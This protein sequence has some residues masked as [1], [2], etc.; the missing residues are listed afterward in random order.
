V[1]FAEKYIINISIESLAKFHEKLKSYGFFEDS[2]KAPCPT[3]PTIWQKRPLLQRIL[4]VKIK[5]FNPDRLLNEFMPLA[6]ILYSRYIMP[7]YILFI[8]VAFMTLISNRLELAGQ[9]RLTFTP[10]A[11]PLIYITVIFVTILHELS[12]GFVCKLRGG[13]ITEVGLLLLYFQLLFYTNISDAYLFPNK[14]DRI[15]VTVAGIK[16]Q[17]LVWALAVLVWRITAPET[18]FNQMSYIIIALS[19]LLVMFNINPLLKLDAYYYLVDKWGIPNLRARAFGYWKQRIFGI[20]EKYRPKIDYPAREI[21]IYKWYGLAAIIYSTGLFGYM[22][23]K[24]SGFIFS[25]IGILGVAALYVFVL[26]MVVEALRKAGFW[27]VIM[28]ESRNDSSIRAPARATLTRGNILRPR[29]W[30]IIAVVVAGLALLS[31]IVRIDLKISQDCL[32]YPVESVTLTA[33]DA[34]YIEVTLDKGLGEKSVQR[35]NLTGQNL[36]VLS[37][38]PTVQEGEVVTAGQL[39]AKI[40][41]TESEANLIES[42][43]NLD[44]AHSQLTLLKKGPRPEEIAKTQ[45]QIEQAK[46]KLKKSESDLTR[47]EELSAKGMIPIQ[48]LDED[49]TTRDV[50]KSELDFYQKQKRLLKNGA[51]PEEIAMAKADINALQAQIDRLESQLAANNVVSPIN[52]SVVAIKTGK[53][54]LTVAR[55]DTMRISIP[56]PE[57]EISPIKVGQDV[58]LKVR[59]YPG[60][61]FDGVVAQISSQTESGQLQPVFIVTA[62]AYNNH[63][64]LK[65]GM[66]GHAKIYCGKRPIS[67]ILLWRA[68]RWFRV[69]FWSWY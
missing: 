31:A 3:A 23:Y 17:I 2:D 5:A 66:T 36:N 62:K 42:R 16:N 37:I 55:I 34:G 57:K 45:D 58:K 35:L 49:R 4:F 59:G 12:H 19:F 22:I 14:K 47:S 6:R 44:H 46:M 8:F 56:V 43:A 54:I 52:G 39:I 63:S 9:L 60:L 29:N 65:P 48:K 11:I 50:L 25:K 26:Y 1:S 27:G 61:T 7:L 24:L 10:G 15:A 20:L 13:K 41:S 33:N 38:D 18:I 21:R 40:H 53:D 68:V 51:R 32:I 64:L 28:S 69:E 67:K 30:I